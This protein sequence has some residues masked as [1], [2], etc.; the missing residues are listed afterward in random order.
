MGGVSGV[1]GGFT[2]AVSRSFCHSHSLHLHQP[3]STQK[4]MNMRLILTTE[5]PPEHAPQRERK[6]HDGRK[7]EG[8]N[9]SRQ[10]PACPPP[11]VFCSSVRA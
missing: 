3:T 4:R 6:P 10:H 11:T 1:E 2:P 5:V 9:S 7:D 8:G